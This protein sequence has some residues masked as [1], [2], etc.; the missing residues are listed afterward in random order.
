MCQ[1]CRANNMDLVNART[2][3][4]ATLIS[5]WKENHNFDNDGLPRSVWRTIHEESKVLKYESRFRQNESESSSSRVSA[6]SRAS[7]DDFNNQIDTILS[8][9]DGES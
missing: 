9:Q 2:D 4:P 3:L 6:A 7:N 5:A 1:Q 8:S